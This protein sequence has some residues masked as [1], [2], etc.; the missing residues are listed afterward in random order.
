[1]QSPVLA[2]IVLSVRPP[3]C[4]SVTRWHCVKTTQARI[5]KTSPTDSPSTIVLPI[6]S[7]SRN[8]KGFTPMNEG[9]KWEWGRKIHNFQPIS[10]RIS[11]TVQDRTNVTINDYRK[12]HTP[13]PLVT[14]STTLHDLE[15]PIRTLLQKVGLSE[16]TTKIWTRKRKPC[17]RKEAARC[18]SCSVPFLVRRKHNTTSLSV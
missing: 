16:P 13:F 12:P 2:T 15:Q 9:F 1:M 6:K 10:R 3:I 11:E 8:S 14:K 5:T 7:S 18:H 4:L 17:C